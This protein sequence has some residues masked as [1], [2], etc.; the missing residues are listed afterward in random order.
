MVSP[1]GK[2]AGLFVWGVWATAVAAALALVAAHGWNIP[3]WDDYTLVPL[4]TRQEPVTP[5]WLWDQ[6]NEH[7]IPLPKL[8][9]LSAVAAAG[10]DFRAGMYLSV[11]GLAAAAA[12][13]VLT[14]AHLRGHTSYADAFF[15]L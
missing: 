2:T 4:L 14:A 3:R 12:G 8:A 10:W 11:A 13:L 9:L 1:T 7:R 15:P 5:S 6:H